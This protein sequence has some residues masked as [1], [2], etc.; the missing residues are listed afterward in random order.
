MKTST[1]HALF[2]TTKM[3]ARWTKGRAM[4]SAGRGGS[5]RGSCWTMST[6]SQASRSGP[7]DSKRVCSTLK[8]RSLLSFLS[9][10]SHFTVITLSL[11]LSFR[12]LSAFPSR[13]YSRE[14][15][16]ANAL[17][18]ARSFVLDV[19]DAMGVDTVQQIRNPLFLD[20]KLR[21]FFRLGPST[22]RDFAPATLCEQSIGD[23]DKTEL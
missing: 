11:F 16:R 1:A 20:I 22:Q 17:A 5:R 3:M 7:I 23:A 9:L 14:R 18:L 2:P 10:P 19:N 4:E 6:A 12:Q 21:L 15:E 13:V 8:S